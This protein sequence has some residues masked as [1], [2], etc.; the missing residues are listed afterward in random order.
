MASIQ[1]AVIVNA[2][3]AAAAKK[4]VMAAMEDMHADSQDRML[5]PEWVID[6]AEVAEVLEW[7]CGGDELVHEYLDLYRETWE[8]NLDNLRK[9]LGDTD[10]S[11]VYEDR[12]LYAAASVAGRE[13]GAWAGWPV[14]VYYLGHDSY[15]YLESIRHHHD[16]SKGILE[17]ITEG[18]NPA[19]VAQ[20]NTHY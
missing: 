14:K 2:K 19:W 5:P 3:T 10:A 13:M 6:G 9:T 4:S 15:D 12:A 11:D 17:D 7:D 1:I 16:L 18:S 8:Q 20:V